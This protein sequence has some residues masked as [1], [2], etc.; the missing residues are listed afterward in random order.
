MRVNSSSAAGNLVSDMV[1]VVMI[2]MMLAIR[3]GLTIPRLPGCETSAI[4][5]RG[6]RINDADD[7]DLAMSMLGTEDAIDQVLGIADAFAV[8]SLGRF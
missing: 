7:D 4:N 6:C 5:A 1:M 3:S 8:D 2:M